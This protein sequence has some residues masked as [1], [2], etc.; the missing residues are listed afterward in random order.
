MSDPYD[1]VVNLLAGSGRVIPKRDGRGRDSVRAKCPAHHDVR[2]S[3][4]VTRDGSN[5]LLHCFGGC[6]I[7]R[8]VAALGLK[9]PDEAAEIVRKMRDERYGG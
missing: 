8:V 1:R 6:S 5:V 3:L 7:A 4:S 9:M 2:P